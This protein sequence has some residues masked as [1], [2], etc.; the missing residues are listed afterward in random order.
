MARDRRESRMFESITRRSGHVKLA[1]ACGI[2][3][4]I[5]AGA[6]GTLVA[7]RLLASWP[8]PDQ[9]ARCCEGAVSRLRLAAMR[10]SRYFQIA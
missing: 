8:S 1:I 7:S 9:S 6:A 5:A 4:A 10:R 2:I 3:V